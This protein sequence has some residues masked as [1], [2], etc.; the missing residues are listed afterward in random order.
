MNKSGGSRPIVLILEDEPMVMLGAVQMFEAVGFEALV[1]FSSDE[2]LA[3]LEGRSGI[4]VVFSEFSAPGSLDG[5]S[6][7]RTVRGRW[8]TVEIIVVS[9]L[10]G[11]A[12][13]DLPLGTRYFPKPYAMLE[14]QSAL[15]ELGLLG[16]PLSP[17]ST[18]PPRL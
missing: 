3:H 6:F 15:E 5:D 14:V 4:V 12:P 10:V 2:A 1:A 9:K 11:E 16:E 18:L 17:R 7:A 8:P 13:P